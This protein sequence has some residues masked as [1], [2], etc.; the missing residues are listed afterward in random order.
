MKQHRMKLVALAT[1]VAITTWLMWSGASSHAAHAFSPAASPKPTL[2]LSCGVPA[3]NVVACRL[4]GH[5]FYPNEQIA[6]SYHLA[7]PALP[8]IRGSYQGKV[9]S[10]AGHTNGAGAFT[11]PTLSFSVARYNESYRLTAIVTGKRSDRASVT[12]VGIAQ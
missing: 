4:S 8:K 5:S 7:Y 10:R 2:T 12:A 9:W 1:C 11:R 3:H 6:I